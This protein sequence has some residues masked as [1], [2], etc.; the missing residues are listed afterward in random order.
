MNV[1][2]V[3]TP[4]FLCIVSGIAGAAPGASEMVTA[5]P[6]T[7]MNRRL[8]FRDPFVRRSMRCGRNGRWAT[9]VVIFSAQVIG[10]LL[11]RFVSNCTH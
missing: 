1:K 2:N 6:I 7:E 10:A 4:Y 9:A 8:W 11:S 5:D 3:E